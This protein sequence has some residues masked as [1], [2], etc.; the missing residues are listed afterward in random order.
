ML[1]GII[2]TLLERIALN[3]I[4]Y[5]EYMLVYICLVGDIYPLVTA[6]KNQEGTERRC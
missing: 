3:H 1:I 5:G 4:K 6:K 2:I